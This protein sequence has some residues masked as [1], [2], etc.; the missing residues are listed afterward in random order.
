MSV[1]RRSDAARSSHGRSARDR[2][3]DVACDLFYRQGVRAVG[4]D[5]IITEAGVAKMS[6]YRAFPS[7]DALIVACLERREAEFWERWE[8]TMLL[9]AGDP[10]AQLGGVL[11]VV[12][13]RTLDRDYRGCPFLNTAT[14]FPDR[15]LPANSLI[16]ERKLEVNAKL[17]EIAAAAGVRDPQMLA[18]QLQLIV[19]GAYAAG[20]TLGAEGSGRALASTGQVL[21]AA[22]LE[23]ASAPS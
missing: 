21:I 18:N 17:Q 19:D 1:A 4:I 5:T 15:S 22:A 14:E 16:R 12:M 7:K 11:E 8:R 13:G 9:H 10:R 20:Q 2:I 3:L 23:P 6:L